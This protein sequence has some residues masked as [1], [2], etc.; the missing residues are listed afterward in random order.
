M[1]DDADFQDICAQRSARMRLTPPLVRM[2]LTSPYVTPSPYTSAKNQIYTPTPFSRF[3]LNMRRKAEILKYSSHSQSTQ[4]NSMTKQ[5]RWAQIARG[6]I[7]KQFTY[8]P[9][10]QIATVN[11]CVGDK[12][13]PTPTSSCDVPG[14]VVYLYEDEGVPLYM[15]AYNTRSNPN[16]QNTSTD[17]Y[18]IRAY[19]DQVFLQNVSNVAMTIG[20]TQYNTSPSMSIPVQIP[21]SIRLYGTLASTTPRQIIYAYVER[22]DVSIFYNTTILATKTDVATNLSRASWN[23]TEGLNTANQFN[24]FRSIGTYSPTLPAISVTDG[25]VYDVQFKIRIAVVDSS[26]NAI[27]PSGVTYEVIGSPSTG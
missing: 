20:I 23:M 1:S 15:Y 21:L 9:I 10:T 7:E 8:D 11:P 26:N 5:Q 19:P 14:P 27:Y 4:T 25:F 6:N 12:T 18:I 17:A 22:I 3:Q 16:N 13:I 2:E 24:V